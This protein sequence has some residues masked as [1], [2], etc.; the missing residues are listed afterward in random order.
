MTKAELVSE[1]A[2]NTGVDKVAVLKTVESF[3]DSNRSSL[4]HCF[5]WQYKN[6]V[7]R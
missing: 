3:M 2:D 5:S 6:T 1:I 4:F 7:F